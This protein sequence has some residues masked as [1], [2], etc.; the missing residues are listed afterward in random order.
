MVFWF[1][2]YR[3]FIWISLSACYGGGDQ[4][5]IAGSAAVILVRLEYLVLHSAAVL[6]WGICIACCLL[7]IVEAMSDQALQSVVAELNQHFVT[8]Y[9]IDEDRVLLSTLVKPD[10][11]MALS[12]ENVVVATLIA[13]ERERFATPKQN[14]T[15]SVGEAT[16][17]YLN[18]FVLFSMYFNERLHGESLKFLSGVIAFFQSK[19]VFTPQNTSGL[20]SSFEKLIFEIRNQTFHEQ[21]NMWSYLGCKYL[22][23]VLFKVRMVMIDEGNIDFKV[24]GVS[25]MGPDLSNQ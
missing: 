21:S 19:N 6:R 10:G 8:K 11:G 17:I 13:I 20:D 2:C 7:G 9:G 15:L 12:D 4:C 3:L 18:L 16:P 24:S 1:S 23:S 22:P 5:F 14:A 25:G